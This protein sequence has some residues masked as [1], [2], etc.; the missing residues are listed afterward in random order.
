MAD[1][2]G[3]LWTLATLAFLAGPG[4]LP[5]P[6]QQPAARLEGPTLETAAYQ[7]PVGS[8]V[9]VAPPE[10]PVPL[11]GWY[12]NL[13]LSIVKPH[14]ESRLSSGM[15]VNPAFPDPVHLP[16]ADQ[17]WTVAPQLQLGCRLE[18]GLGEVRLGYRCAETDGN[19]NLPVFD[20]PGGGSL[21]SRLALHTVDLDYL[22]SES[23]TCLEVWPPCLRD[24]RFGLGVR[25]A[26]AY[27][28]SQAHGQAILAENA[29]SCFWGIGPH[30][31]VDYR[32]PLPGTPV[33]FFAQLEAAGLYGDVHQHYSESQVINQQLVYGEQVSDD[34]STAI[35]ILSVSGGIEWVPE[36]GNRPL[37]LFAGYQYERWWNFGRTETTNAE[38]TMQ[39]VLLR[40]EYSY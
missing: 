37:R 11:P 30:A 15:P 3:R 17:D 5:I 35:G 20:T 25:V 33:W 9:P 6:G 39:G 13:E 38:L 40:L 32:K 12:A 8:V 36:F 2:M 16:V 21:R 28:D 18:Q 26:A 22:T 27:F 19:E 34:Q 31:A 23:G 24:F 4:V 7:N 14:I 29:C 1:R 10:P